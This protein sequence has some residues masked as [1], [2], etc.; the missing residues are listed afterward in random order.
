MKEPEKIIPRNDSDY[1]RVMT[2]AVFQ[3]GFS[4][5]VIENKWPGFEK[6]FDNFDPYI[7]ATYNSDKI[8]SLKQDTGIVRNSSKIEATIF[9][10]QTLLKKNEEFGSMKNYLNAQGDFENTVK[11]LRKSFKWLGDL[12]AYY[13]LWVVNE[14]VPSYEDWCKSRGV[15]PKKIHG[16]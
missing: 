12:G 2:K 8:L 15:S 11:D 1:L 14:P 7:V 4:W 10:S 9:N 16:S 6:V 3:A 13:F 5:Q